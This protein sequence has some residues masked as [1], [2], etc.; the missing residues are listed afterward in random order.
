MLAPWVSIW[1][2]A[3]APEIHPFGMVRL[4]GIFAN[5]TETPETRVP[6]VI[7]CTALGTVLEHGTAGL[8][9]RGQCGQCRARTVA[10]F[11]SA[12]DRATGQ[13]Q[14]GTDCAKK[15]GG[16]KLAIFSIYDQWRRCSRQQK[17]TTKMGPA[18]PCDVVL[19]TTCQPPAAR[20]RRAHD[21]CVCSSQ[22]AQA[23][24]R[25]TATRHAVPA[26]AQRTTKTP[27]RLHRTHM[28]HRKT[29]DHLACTYN[30]IAAQ[31]FGATLRCDASVRR[32][33]ATA[34]APTPL[35]AGSHIVK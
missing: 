19:S 22:R 17:A 15:Q 26:A 8:P 33:A 29:H 14:D 5:V 27:R 12:R 13:A 21:L 34:R 35:C 31:R 16:P 1:G 7:A 11:F 4:Y 25:N 9:G 32:C 3:G 10:L 30:F 2:A 20:R 28:R 24:S 6:C 23:P 18:A